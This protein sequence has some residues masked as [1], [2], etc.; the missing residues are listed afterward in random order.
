VD[1]LLFV[2]V[3]LALVAIAGATIF[4]IRRIQF[5]KLPPEVREG[6]HRARDARA[7]YRR[8]RKNY[9]HRVSSAQG[10]LHAMEDPRGR[11]VKSGGG[12]QLYERWID[13]PQ[14][15]GSLIGVR[16]RAEDD[17]Y[18]LAAHSRAPQQASNGNAAESI[19]GN[20]YVV[21]DG[22]NVSGVAVFP[23]SAG[24]SPMQQ[25][26]TFSAEVNNAARAAEKAESMLPD[27][28]EAARQQL[29]AAN[30]DIATVKKA[31]QEYAAAVAL[32]PA[33]YREKFSDASS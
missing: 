30:K 23:A 32:L 7:E 1:V 11:L 18:A 27:R 31:R 5:S 10:E 24:G 4:V 2:F 20:A 17:P 16:A 21:I 8:V 14:G 29:E 6:I 19:T 3:A 12:V 13:T 33:H 9:E 25:A 15:G 22:P 28:I 26:L